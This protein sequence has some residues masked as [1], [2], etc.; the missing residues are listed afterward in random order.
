MFGAAPTGPSKHFQPPNRLR[1][2]FGQ[3]LSVRHVSNPRDSGGT[4]ADQRTVLKVGL[5]DR[6]QTGGLA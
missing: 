5:K 1:L 4:I 2:R 6:L 3:K